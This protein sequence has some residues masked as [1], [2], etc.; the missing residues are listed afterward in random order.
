MPVLTPRRLALF[1]LAVC[2]GALAAAYA[3]QY[4]LDQRPCILCLYQ[5]VPYAVAG[6]LALGV[7]AWPAAGRPAFALVL[8][9][10]LAGAGLAG[11][12]MG[13]EQHWWAG[14]EGCEGTLDAG[15]T[16]EQLRAQLAQAPLRR[17]DEI[18]WSILGVSITIFNLIGSLGMA[19]LVLIGRSRMTT[20]DRP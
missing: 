8:L 16:L 10:F 6:A 2:V 12:H 14:T 1:V 20:E 18:T 13:V 15:L 9:A 11:H 3:A 7:L 4:L 5:R 17:C 19:A